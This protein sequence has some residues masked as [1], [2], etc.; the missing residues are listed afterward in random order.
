MQ[1][2][3]EE[4]RASALPV[5]GAIVPH[6]GL[7]YSGACAAEVFKRVR[8]A[9]TVVILA[10]NH[11][12]RVGAPGGASAWTTGAFETPLGRHVIAEKFLRA[13]CR[14][15]DLVAHDPVAHER[16]HA[17]EV[18]LP[19]LSLL[20]PQSLIA[21]IV[22]AWDD[23][24]RCR[25]LGDA[26][27]NAVRGWP[28][29]VSLLASS[30]MTHFETAASAEQ[31]DRVA[32]EHIAQLDG[33]GLLEACARLPITMCGRAPA[34][35]VLHAAKALGATAGELVDYRHS[36]WVTGDDHSVVA[37]AGVIIP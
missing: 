9:P 32:L 34:A 5:R 4:V 11:T 25:E 6:A 24:E 22:L 30:D 12:G 3:L 14:E 36:G 31:K 17:I 23:W 2:L 7:E 33:A 35:T 20:A 15:C 18:E 16:E 10:P 21:P 27:A 29:P 26:L 13:L 1:G 19:F 8:L 28:E 37:Y